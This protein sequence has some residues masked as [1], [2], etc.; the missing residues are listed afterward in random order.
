[1]LGTT[2][3]AICLDHPWLAVGPDRL[4]PTREAIYLAYLATTASDTPT[5]VIRSVDGGKT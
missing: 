1:M 2:G 3:Q 5:V 4:D